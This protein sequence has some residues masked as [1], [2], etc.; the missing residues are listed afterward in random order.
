MSPLH[1]P[2]ARRR[3]AFATAACCLAALVPFT[4]L[5]GA[6]IASATTLARAS[7]TVSLQENGD[8]HLTSNHGFT[9]NE[10]GAGSGTVKGTIYVHLTIVSTKR[11][12]R[13][14]EH[15]PSTAARSPAQASAAY[16]R[17]G[18]TGQLR[19]AALDHARHAAAT[20]TRTARA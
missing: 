11:G 5:T 1:T 2:S 3:G 16:R 18:A 8:L 7:K 20:P 4:S 15:L 19:R 12:D 9:L 13:R 14:N 6:G 10:Q 17:E